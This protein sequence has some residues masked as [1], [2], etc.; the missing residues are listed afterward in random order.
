MESKIKREKV[1]FES[2]AADAHQ[3]VTVEG[4]C[5]LA[6]SMRDAVT[7]LSVQAQANIAQ[8]QALTDRI[9]VKGRVCF[10]VLY[11]Q[12]DLTKIRSI[13]TTCD[14]VHELAAPGAAP[15]MRVEASAAVHETNG[16]AGS[17]RMA[18][19]ALLKLR[20]QV[21][22]RREEAA[23]ADLDG[24]QTLCIRRQTALSQLCDLLGEE[25]A[26]IR[27]EFDLHERLQ[28]DG[29]LTATGT[30]T[31]TDITGG[32][33]R[34]GVSGTIEARVIHQPG[35]PGEPLVETTHELPFQ[36]TISAQASEGAKLEAAAEVMDVVADSFLAD[37]QRTMRVEAEVRVRL[38]SREE[39]STELLEDVYSIDGPAIQP[40][41]EEFDMCI[42]QSGEEVRESLRI[43]AVLPSDAPPA[44]TVL[45]AFA[46]PVLSSVQPAGRR[47][48][49][50]G[51]MNITLVY[52]PLDSDI[53]YAV[54]T[55]E[56]FAMTFPTEA[57]EGVRAQA[58]VIECGVGP[59]TSDRV[60]LRCVLALRTKGNSIRRVRIVRDIAEQPEEKRG[61]GFVL[62]WPAP[63]ESRWDTAKR[64][65]VPQESLR[66]A[67][68]NALLAFRK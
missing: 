15:G 53:P 43:S 12:G 45:A 13:E 19:R 4:E 67:G 56:P 46:Q 50:E 68:G 25:T 47:I 54:R 40:I 44:D 7:I 61:H 41:A 11:T 48:G 3:Q 8:T 59:A 23:I 65:R 6:G 38:I 31:V 49:A 10:Q 35:R 37:K 51:V 21:F 32:N 9:G 5:A 55:R 42:A 18:L 24:E 62:I 20:A 14:F 27:E 66:S 2:L 1:R 30:A 39:Q 60:E 58:A 29:V 28:T 17:G 16:T 33:G 36:V 63:E 52:L 22:D 57:V 26:L 34:I 64:L